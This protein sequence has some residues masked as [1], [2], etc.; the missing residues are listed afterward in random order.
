MSIKCLYGYDR[1]YMSAEG[2]ILK[3]I[4]SIKTV[5]DISYASDAHDFYAKT[6]ALVI[7]TTL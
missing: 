6:I 4:I 5:D 2:S 1:T 7:S 3:K